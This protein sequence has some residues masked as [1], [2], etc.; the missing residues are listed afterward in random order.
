MYELS[1]LRKW[2]WLKTYQYFD[3]QNN[4]QNITLNFFQQT[5]R[6]FGCYQNTHLLFVWQRAHQIA[7]D[8]HYNMDNFELVGFNT[9][10]GNEAFLTGQERADQAAQWIQKV[11]GKPCLKNQATLLCDGSQISYRLDDNSFNLIHL[12]RV[13]VPEKASN[14]HY[15]VIFVPKEKGKGKI[16]LRLGRFKEDD[17]GVSDKNVLISAM[18]KYMPHYMISQSL[19]NSSNHEIERQEENGT[20]ADRMKFLSS[21]NIEKISEGFYGK[22]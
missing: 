4:L 3:D 8:Y 1:I 15:L 22:N 2:T 5:A 11:A 10:E 21:L 12:S 19:P 6:Y 16:Q 17:D 13:V 7:C 20:F 14:D 18:N 9:K